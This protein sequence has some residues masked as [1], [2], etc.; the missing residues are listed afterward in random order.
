MVHCLTYGGADLYETRIAGRCAQVIGA[1]HECF[2]IEDKYF[3]SRLQIEELVK[4]TESANYFEWFG[5]IEKA[6][7]LGTKPLLLLGDLCESVD[8]RYMTTFST[9]KARIN[10]YLGGMVG[11]REVFEE[12]SESA[13]KRWCDEKALEIKSQLLANIKHL[14]PDLPGSLSQ[15]QIASEIE[16]DLGTSFARVGAQPLRYSS[17]YDEVFIWFHRIRF[18]LGNQI[19]WLSSGFRP[20]SP[21]LSMRFLR[22]I[23]GV[24]PKHRV[25]K[26]LMNSIIALPEFDRLSRI[27]SAQIPFIS[28][29]A[30]A[31]IKDALWGLR[32]GAD[33]ILIKRNLKSRNV[34]GRQRV[35]RSI[36]YVREYRRESTSANVEDWFSGR[37]IKGDDY[38]G[39]LRAR[40]ELNAWTLINVD[41]TAPANVSIILDLCNPETGQS[42]AQDNAAVAFRG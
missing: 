33:Q 32:S 23:T 20:A 6:R 5:I 14:A 38:L 39:K 21:G 25:R 30:P 16:R 9:R 19:N 2:P 27:P 18:L 42:V 3:P 40:A 36:D 35:L 4:E 22:L 24:H 28:S 34:R 13:F 8:G 15:A 41:I 12:A 31:F 17:M 37:F 29:R 7:S 26:R 10:S 11:K 1:S